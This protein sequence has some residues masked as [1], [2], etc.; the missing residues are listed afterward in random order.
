MKTETGLKEKF[1]WKNS[2]G[3]VEFYRRSLNLTKVKLAELLGVSDSIV[4]YWEKGVKEPKASNLV[5]LA[6]VF[7]VSETELLHPSA[8]II[9]K[10]NAL[11]L[12]NTLESS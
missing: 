3:V 6:R 11:K 7:G 8:E 9:G 2:C 5:K 12:T 4:A 10:I 1:E